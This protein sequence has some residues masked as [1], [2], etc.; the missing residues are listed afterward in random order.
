MKQVDNYVQISLA[1]K[2]QRVWSINSLFGLADYYKEITVRINE[3]RFN[4][5]SGRESIN[6]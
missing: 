1:R 3:L 4:Y 6:S 5:A 2:R